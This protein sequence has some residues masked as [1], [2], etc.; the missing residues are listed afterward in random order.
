MKKKTQYQHLH[1][2]PT[3]E[4]LRFKRA[5]GKRLELI[6]KEFDRGFKFLYHLK[7]E[8]TFFGSARLHG[9]Y[10]E[11]ARELAARLAKEGYT[12]I[13]GGGPGIMEA[14]NKGAVEG[15]GVS[16]GLNIELP[17]EQRINKYV[18]KALGFHYFFSRKVIMS[19]SAQAYVFFP[20]G[21]GTIDEFFELVVLIQTRKMARVP[22]I[23]VGEKFWKPLLS[24]I[25]TVLRDEY[26]T[27]S[28]GDTSIYMCA[29]N[30]DEAFDLVS[31]SRER[32]YF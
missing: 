2:L 30:L 19:A 24:Y 11:Q 32:R 8:I 3:P 26:K 9:E 28:P 18:K 25:E 10:Y 21:F 1:R 7:N 27:I 15:R 6:Q 5:K 31:A 22:I 4:S 14:A 13:T 17:M 16:V 12:I 29:K 20:G 23:L